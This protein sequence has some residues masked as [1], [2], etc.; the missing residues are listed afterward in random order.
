MNAVKCNKCLAVIV[1]HHRHD[2]VACNCTNAA[3]RVAIDGGNEIVV[4][5][6]YGK[7]ASYVQIKDVDQLVALGGETKRKPY[8]APSFVRAKPTKIK[9]SSMKQRME[10]AIKDQQRR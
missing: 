8:K 9:K 4:R 7:N 5:R 1:S 10:Q 3:D 6:V 2:Y